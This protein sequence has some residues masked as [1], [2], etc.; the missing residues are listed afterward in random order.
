MVVVL[1]EGTLVAL[2]VGAPLP[3]RLWRRSRSL[4][5]RI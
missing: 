4:A 3:W 5:E 2:L 1:E